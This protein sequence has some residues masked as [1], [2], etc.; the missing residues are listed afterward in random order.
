MKIEACH[1]HSFIGAPGYQGN[2]P[3]VRPSIRVRFNVIVWFRGG[4]TNG[5]LVG[6]IPFPRCHYS[7]AG[8]GFLQYFSGLLPLNG[9]FTAIK[10]N[11]GPFFWS[12]MLVILPSW[13]CASVIDKSRGQIL[14]ERCAEVNCGAF[15]GG[16][17]C[18]P[19][20]VSPK[21]FCAKPPWNAAPKESEVGLTAG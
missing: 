15:C 21:E 18:H 14:K 7:P 10:P 16:K 4:Q 13:Q 1:L 6:P 17:L 11:L 2:G 3:L 19:Y 20:I 8:C 12:G 5:Q 9:M